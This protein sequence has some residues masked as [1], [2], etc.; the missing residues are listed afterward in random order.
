[1]ISEQENYAFFTMEMHCITT[2]VA[3][4][5]QYQSYFTKYLPRQTR[6]QHIKSP[7]ETY[8]ESK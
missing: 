5:R 1:M 8:S 6:K 3:V 4:Q 2:T 7:H